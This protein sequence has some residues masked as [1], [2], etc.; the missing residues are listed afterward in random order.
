M[1]ISTLGDY[2]C[3]ETKIYYGKCLASIIIL[4][5]EDI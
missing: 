4:Y 3:M 2:K 1:H 5:F